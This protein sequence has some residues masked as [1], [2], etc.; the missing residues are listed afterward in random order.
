MGRVTT[1]SPSGTFGGHS[2]PFGDTTLR[3]VQA[4][5]KKEDEHR[6]SCGK[7]I[8]DRISG[9]GRIE[10]TRASPSGKASAFQADIRGFDPHRPLLRFP[11]YFLL[12]SK[13]D[14]RGID[15]GHFRC[16]PAIPTARSSS[17]H[18]KL[19]FVGLTRVTSAALLRSPPPALP[20]ILK[21]IFVGLTKVT[22]IVLSNK[23]SA[24]SLDIKSPAKNNF[25]KGFCGKYTFNKSFCL[26][27][28]ISGILN[29]V[30]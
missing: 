22:T 30:T 12:F 29:S 3:S 8:L 17:I 4:F 1:I 14:I 27:I 28:F 16:A 15:Y 18:L 21:L 20:S 9:N 24:R 13:A 2:I 11:P 7:R 10:I 23:K 26:T 5:G 6:S 19:I 25:L